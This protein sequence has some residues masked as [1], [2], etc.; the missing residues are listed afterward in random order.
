[1]SL[2]I[3]SIRIKTTT[4]LPPPHLPLITNSTTLNCG[5][6]L[7]NLGSY[8]AI[9]ALLITLQSH[10]MHFPLVLLKFWVPKKSQSFL[11]LLFFPLLSSPLSNFFLLLI[12]FYLPSLST[13]KS[14]MQINKHN[15]CLRLCKSLLCKTGLLWIS[16][17][18]RLSANIIIT[19]CWWPA[20]ATTNCT[21]V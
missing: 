9:M 16:S 10:P 17:Q 13:S 12:S 14:P 2:P 4:P 20:N 7:H 18:E 21:V 3:V 1:M 8:Q 5:S 11:N 19:K 6:F 15:F